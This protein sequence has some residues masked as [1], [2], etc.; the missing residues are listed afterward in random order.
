MSVRSL[1][2][3]IAGALGNAESGR[4]YLVGDESLRFSDFFQLFFDAV[5]SSRKVIE[6]DQEHPLL[7]DPFIVP[8]RGV[9][10]AYEPDPAEVA[11]LGYTRNDVTR[12]VRE[13]VSL[14]GSA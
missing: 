9:R 6:R 8:G 12:A 7:P 2:E 4:A 13:V 11:L 3:A 10:L 1:S 5:G 14:V